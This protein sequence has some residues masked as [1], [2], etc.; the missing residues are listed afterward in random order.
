M[1]GWTGST[2][3]MAEQIVAI[4]SGREGKALR[5]R[6]PAPNRAAA[7]VSTFDKATIAHE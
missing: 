7:R 5:K 1:G 3:D 6:A 2:T 4:E